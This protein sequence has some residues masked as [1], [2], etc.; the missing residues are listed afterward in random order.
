MHVV[1]QTIAEVMVIAPT[2]HG[3]AR[4]YFFES[5][6]R[7]FFDAHGIRVE[8]VQ[9]NMSSSVRGV[10]RGLHYQLDP[11]AQGKLV[12]VVRGEVFDVAVDLR[13]GAPTFGRWVGCLLSAENKYSMYV[14]PGFAHG[15]CVVSAVAEFHY[16]CSG[17]YAPGHERSL[18]W[19]DP[20]LGITWPIA[21][22]EACLSAKDAQAPGLAAA[23]INYLYTP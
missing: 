18:L 19:N 17:Y 12:R 7:D 9:D 22:A 14:P 21:G 2:V 5:Y 15:F 3:D 11:H 13:R 16:K 4:G 10:V 20:A 23:E 1:P 8:F 6:R